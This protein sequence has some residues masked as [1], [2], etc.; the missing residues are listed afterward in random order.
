MLNYENLSA[1]CVKELFKKRLKSSK[2]TTFTDKIEIYKCLENKYHAPK[3]LMSSLKKMRDLRHLN[4][5]IDFF[6]FLRK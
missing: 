3:Y 5:K 1:T 6:C 2:N 4:L